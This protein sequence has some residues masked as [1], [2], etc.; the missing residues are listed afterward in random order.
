MIL[1]TINSQIA[2]VSWVCRRESVIV[3]IENKF[4]ACQISENRYV[5]IAI[6]FFM[7]AP[8]KG[9]CVA[10]NTF[11]LTDVAGSV[12][13]GY[14]LTDTEVIQID[15]SDIHET[16]DSMEEEFRINS[17]G[18]VFHP[19]LLE[20]ELGAGFITGQDKLRNNSGTYDSEN[21]YYDFS[22]RFNILKNKPYP[23]S[24]YYVQRN[25]R[26]AV[27]VA[28]SL[29]I[30]MENYG[31]SFSL[32]SPLVKSPVSLSFDHTQSKGESALSVVDDSRDNLSLNISTNIGDIGSGRIGLNTVS[33]TSG[34]GSRNLPLQLSTNDTESIDWDAKVTLG[35]ERNIGIANHLIISSSEQNNAPGRDQL[36]FYN[37]IDWQ[38]DDDNDAYNTV[39]F[40]STDYDRN[41]SSNQNFVIGVTRRYADSL[42][43]TAS[44]DAADDS[45]DGFKRSSYSFNGSVLNQIELSE[46]WMS[47]LGYSVISRS[48]SQTSDVSTISVFDEIHTLNG[49]ASISLTHEYVLS[50]SVTVSNQTHS[51]DYVENIDYK[52]ITVG[53]E[54]RLERLIS[55]NIADGQTVLISYE[56][57]AGGT[58]DFDELKQS[59]NLSFSLDH[60]YNYWLLYTTNKQIYQ[61]GIP[62]HSMESVQNYRVGMDAQV[63]INKIADYGW[64]MEFEKR[65]EDLR[66]F[67]RSSLDLNLNS[68]LPFSAA[69]M[70]VNAGYQ[71]V[72]NELSPNDIRE[73]Y[74]TTNISA[75]TGM[76]STT[77]FEWTYRKDTGGDV[78]KESSYAK[79]LYAWSRGHLAF[80]LSARYSKE[81]QGITSRKN[82]IVEASLTRDFR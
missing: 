54:T 76:A 12:R 77:S 5:W 19:N 71:Q 11:E 38:V 13:L 2:S 15:G 14:S 43:I 82:S 26:Q 28:D 81:Q 20:M 67:S 65:V 75:R 59:F 21:E 9:H 23:V 33:Q 68:A 36:T 55:G 40:S 34:S 18:Y 8:S 45:N 37:H 66:P 22:G 44:V 6:I 60:R 3:R 16:R 46:R 58:F 24:L 10:F 79:L 1:M 39:N 7:I 64:R 53:S 80:S 52:V 30:E 62:V 69:F 17:H 63:P 49:L 32:R 42:T 41:E 57:E 4:G 27:G 61:S 31:M 70:S 74:L 72:D 48:N 73:T 35:A 56:Y 78:A 50:G 47:S 51:Q 25:P 29:N